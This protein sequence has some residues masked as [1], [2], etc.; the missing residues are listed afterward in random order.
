MKS[1][2]ENFKYLFQ[3]ED[4]G[5]IGGKCTCVLL[6][7]PNKELSNSQTTVIFRLIL[8]KEKLELFWDQIIDLYS[9]LINLL[10]TR[11]R[12]GSIYLYY[13]PWLEGE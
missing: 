8:G 12:K 10:N 13:G 7:A 1:E 9:F 4:D 5:E 11:D 6:I 3:K 2:I